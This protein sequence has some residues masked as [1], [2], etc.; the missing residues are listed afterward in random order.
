MGLGEKYQANLEKGLAPLV[1]GPLVVATTGQ[2]VGSMAGLFRAEVFNLATTAI[3]PGGLKVSGRAGG[4]VHQAGMQDVRLPTSFAVAITPTSIY[5]YKWKPFWGRVKVKKQLLQVPREGLTVTI[6]KGRATA[7]VFALQ[8]EAAGVRTAFEIATL[9]M[10][11]AKA[12]V[13]D[14]VAALD[15]GQELS[16]DL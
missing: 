12:I 16:R 7:T 14:V 10:S 9:G 5:F 1:D 6:S 4:K 2:P 11:K 15:P 3:D 13:A 8:S